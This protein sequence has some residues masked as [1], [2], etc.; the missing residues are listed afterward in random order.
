[1][2]TGLW[3]TFCLGNE[4]LAS[5]LFLYFDFYTEFRYVLVE[6]TE[7]HFDEPPESN[8]GDCLVITCSLNV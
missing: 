4:T 1:M 8:G 7:E 3:P 6:S 2:M 5:P